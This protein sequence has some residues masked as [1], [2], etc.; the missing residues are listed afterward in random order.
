M[1]FA[2]LLAYIKQYNPKKAIIFSRTK[3][4]ANNIHNLLV[5]QG[6]DAILLH[7]G[8]TQAK[9]ERSLHS[10][11]AGAKFMIATN[12][13]SRGLDIADITDIINFD[14][15]ETAHDYVHR[16]GRSARMGKAGRA[17]TLVGYDEKSLIS[18]I[19]YEANLQM[20][21][22][23][24]SIEEFSKIEALN[25]LKESRHNQRFGGGTIGHGQKRSFGR[26]S[27][28]GRRNFS[29]QGNSENSRDPKRFRSRR[30][31]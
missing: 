3:Y 25:H 29:Q 21:Q 6:F 17:F 15:P 10:F 27:F 30:R 9:R 8:L 19:E 28:A 1:K 23:T 12:V 16:V 5:K 4:E 24:L 7:G 11:R 13:A 18:A 26:G 14:A 31:Y 2:A 20:H 22:I